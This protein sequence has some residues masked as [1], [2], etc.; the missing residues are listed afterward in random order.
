MFATN[1]CM[2][3]GGI[4]VISKNLHVNLKSDRNEL[5]LSAGNRWTGQT[6][7]TPEIV[8]FFEGKVW[9]QQSLPPEFA[10]SQAV[11]VSFE[12]GKV[13]FFDFAKMS[14]GYYLRSRQN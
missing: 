4:G 11:V 1:H 10:L 12:S 13:R 5:I 8:V 14:G 7:L 2:A 6:V 3:K 9:M